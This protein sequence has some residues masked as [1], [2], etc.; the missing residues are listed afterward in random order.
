MGT[1]TSERYEKVIEVA[2]LLAQK[3]GY[4]LD[5]WRLFEREAVAALARM[6]KPQ[7]QSRQ[8]DLAA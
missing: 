8:R 1:Q 6:S 5:A 3:N 2:M 4:G 7:S